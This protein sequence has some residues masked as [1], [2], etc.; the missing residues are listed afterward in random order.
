MVDAEDAN[1]IGPE[2]RHDDVAVCRVHERL[3]RVRRVLSRRIGTRCG[4]G[5]GED[6]EG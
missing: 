6:L 4:H 2:V 1:E 5:E 3:V